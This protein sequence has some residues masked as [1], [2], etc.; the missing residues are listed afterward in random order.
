MPLFLL[1]LVLLAPPLQAEES[2]HR[3]QLRVDGLACAFCAYGIE[4]SFR[5]IPGVKGIDIDLERGLVEI[6]TRPEL[7]F[8]REQLEEIIDDA[9]FTL[10]SVEEPP[11]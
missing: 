6:R 10:R 4:K 2:E 7:R 1:L 9:G 11:S 5:E 3:Y 8:Q